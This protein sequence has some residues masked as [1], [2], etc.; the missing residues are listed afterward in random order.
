[1]FKCQLTNVRKYIILKNYCTGDSCLYY[2]TASKFPKPVTCPTEIL[3]G[4]SLPLRK[5]LFIMALREHCDLAA[6]CVF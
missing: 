4:A 5:K 3:P 1:M 2:S 6:V